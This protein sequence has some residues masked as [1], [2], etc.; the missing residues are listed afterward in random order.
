MHLG[1]DFPGVEKSEVSARR[2][3]QKSAK[4][5]HADA[6][7]TLGCMFMDG[8]GGVKPS[9]GKALRLFEMAAGEGHEDAARALLELSG[10]S[11]ST[12]AR[13]E[14]KNSQDD[15]PS[16]SYED[17]EKLVR[18]VSQEMRELGLS[19]EDVKKL[20]EYD[21]GEENP[22]TEDGIQKLMS[23]EDLDFAAM[24]SLL[25]PD[26]DMREML[27]KDAEGH[28]DLDAAFMLAC[29]MLDGIGGEPIAVRPS[30][31]FMVSANR[32][33]DAAEDML[34]KMKRE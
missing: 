23:G 17:L 14:K 11:E 34:D 9:L 20:V 29:M 5:G 24:R 27:L 12:A 13:D 6:Q 22:W 33:E 16:G 1:D 25:L 7:F 18:K 21:Q 3:L 2:L 19:D 30:A 26:E 4:Q 32:H 31:G 15:T 8:V 10:K 28:G